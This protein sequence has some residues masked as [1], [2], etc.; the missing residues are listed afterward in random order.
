MLK[1]TVEMLGDRAGAVWEQTDENNGA[2]PSA[3][4]RGCR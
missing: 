1:K 3:L 2:V 4:T